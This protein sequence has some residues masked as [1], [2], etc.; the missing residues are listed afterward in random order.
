MD[1][2]FAEQR[3]PPGWIHTYG[4]MEPDGRGLVMNGIEARVTQCF[5]NV[6]PDLHAGEIRGASTDTLE[7]WDSV[8]QITLLTAVSEE[9]SIDFEPEDYVDLISYPQILNAVK[10]RRA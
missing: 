5:A 10:A 2:R 7:A 1:L 3:P 6:F 4:I 8:A 9:F